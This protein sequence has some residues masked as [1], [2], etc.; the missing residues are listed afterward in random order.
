MRGH[1][2]RAN[3]E[4]AELFTLPVLQKQAVGHCH[5]QLTF[6]LG[7]DFFLVIHFQLKKCVYI[8]G[9]ASSGCQ[10]R[11]IA[12]E[13]PVEHTGSGKADGGRRNQNLSSSSVRV[14]VPLYSHW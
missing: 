9:P 8:I 5:F 11:S 12:T 6:V 7:Q 3:G 14:T 4:T 10:H 2:Q 13:P 1:L